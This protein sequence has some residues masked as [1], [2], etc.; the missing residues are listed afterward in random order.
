MS[1]DGSTN[2]LDLFLYVSA[3]HSVAGNANNTA[4]ADFNGDGAINM[5]DLNIYSSLYNKPP[6]PPC[7]GLF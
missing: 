3:Y 6:G 4:D 7:C 2:M 5:L 1:N